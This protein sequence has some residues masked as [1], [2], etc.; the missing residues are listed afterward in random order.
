ME[1]WT[2]KFETGKKE[3]N[4]KAFTMFVLE[5]QM[6]VL[7]EAKIGEKLVVNTKVENKAEVVKGK[8]SEAMGQFASAHPD[9]SANNERVQEQR[10]PRSDDRNSSRCRICSKE[11][12]VADCEKFLAMGLDERVDTCKKFYM[13]FKCL[14]DMTHNFANCGLRTKCNACPSMAHHTLLHGIRRFHPP[15]PCHSIDKIQS[16]MT[17]RDDGSPYSR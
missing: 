11:H 12:Q 17:R 5:K 3:L 16:I 15:C 7:D 14:D 6:F 13:C 4:F 10:T 8:R 2:R 9:A 1:K